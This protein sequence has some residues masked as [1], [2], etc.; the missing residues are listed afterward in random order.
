M[1]IK[2]LMKTPDCLDYATE[3]L[4]EED[5]T[6]LLQIARKWFSYREYV[7]LEIDTEKETC[8]VLEN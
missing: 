8:I 3:Y 7:S 4:N 5:K 2:V 6:K 1:K